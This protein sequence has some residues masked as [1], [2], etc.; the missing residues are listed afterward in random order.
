MFVHWSNTETTYRDME[1]TELSCT[2]CQG[3]QLHTIRLYEKKTKHYSSFS[4]GSTHYVSAICHGCLLETYFDTLRQALLIR[5]YEHLILATEGYELHEKGKT[6]DAI[7]KFRKVL[8]NDPKHPQALYGLA[9]S[10]IAQGKTEEAKSYVDSLTVILPEHE[11][12]K[13][14]KASLSRSL[15]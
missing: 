14:L 13:E 3:D 7:K 2:R 15:Q 11:E 5:K 9:K 12:V 6:N 4:F 10:L 1:K 8:K